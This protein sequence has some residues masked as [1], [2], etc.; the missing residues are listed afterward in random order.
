MEDSYGQYVLHQ[1][2][3][4]GNLELVKYLHQK[5]KTTFYYICFSKLATFLGPGPKLSV[6][7]ELRAHYWSLHAICVAI[8]SF[9]I[10][11]SY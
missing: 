6:V 2:A 11:E 8:A 4:E 3:K 7:L 9:N 1:A 5:G 10:T